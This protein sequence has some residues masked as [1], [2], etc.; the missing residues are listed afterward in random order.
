MMNALDRTNAIEPDWLFDIF[1]LFSKREVNV[2]YLCFLQQYHLV[3][4]CFRNL[5]YIL[6]KSI[7]EGF[8][9]RD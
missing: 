5:D 7:D 1:I 3:Y 2:Y 9:L 8:L 4:T 6:N